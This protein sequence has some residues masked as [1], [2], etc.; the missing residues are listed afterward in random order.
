MLAKS[1]IISWQEDLLHLQNQLTEEAPG[2]CQGFD[3]RQKQR[4]ERV[5][6]TDEKEERHRAEELKRQEAN[7]KVYLEN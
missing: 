7:Q 1:G 4:D 5:L 3:K 2:S 6:K